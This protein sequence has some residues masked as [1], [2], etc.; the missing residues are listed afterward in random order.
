MSTSKMRGLRL[1]RYALAETNQRNWLWLTV[2]SALLEVKGRHG[3]DKRG[4]NKPMNKS[5]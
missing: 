1:Q 3:R 5:K 2:T 4:N